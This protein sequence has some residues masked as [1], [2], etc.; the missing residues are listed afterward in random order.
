MA[1]LNTSTEGS[2]IT[3]AYRSIVESPGPANPSAAASPTYGQWAIFAVQAP[4]LSAFQNDGGKESVLRV[5]RTGEGE[6]EDMADEFS[7]GKI[8]YGFVKVKDPNTTLYKSVFIAWCG[9]GVPERTKGYF[10]SHTAA[11]QKVLHGYH[12]QI[13]ARNDNDL[14]PEN[15]IK[16]VQDSSGSKYS[17]GGA[18]PTAAD[19][20]KPPI[21]SKPVFTPSR[22][23]GGGSNFN[24]LGSRTRPTPAPMGNVDNDGW[25]EDAPSVTRSQIEKVTPA[26]QPTKVNMAELQSQKQES[27]Q[28]QQPEKDT[29]GSSDV[30]RGAY[31]PVGKVDIAAIRREAKEK[32]DAKDDRPTP[33]KGSY[34]PIGKVDIAAIRARAQ[35]PGGTSD[36]SAMSPSATGASQQSA[37]SSENESKSMADRSSAFTGS[38]R[39]S[40]MPKP[41]VANKFGAGAGTFTGTKAPVPGGYDSQTSVPSAPQV[42][43][44]SKTFA[45]QGGKTPAQLWAEKRGKQGAT[46]PPPA[47]DTSRAIPVQTSGGGGGWQ[48]GYTGKKW[49]SVQTTRTGA[50]AAS[51]GSVGA[52]RTGEQEPEPEQ[53]ATSPAGGGV[54]AMRDRFKNA[55]PMGTQPSGGPPPPMDLSSKP[56]AGER[57]AEETQRVPPPPPQVPRPDDEEEEEELDLRP[58]SPIRIAQPIARTAE[59]KEIPRTEEAGEPAPVMPSRSIAQ[60]APAEEDLEP[61]PAVTDHETARGASYAAAAGKRAIAQYDYKKAEENELELREGEEISNIDMV[62]EDW[63]MGENSGGEVGLFPA[64]YVELLPDDEAGPAPTATS[65]AAEAPR[66]AGG[67]GAGVS[68]GKTA[69]AEYD[70][71]AAEDNEL[72]FPEGAVIS[73]VVRVFS[74]DEVGLGVHSADEYHRNSLTRTGG[75]VNTMDRRDC[76]PRIMWCW[77]DEVVTREWVEVLWTRGQELKSQAICEERIECRVN[78]HV[79]LGKNV[80]QVTICRSLIARRSEPC[81]TIKTIGLKGTPPRGTTTLK[82]NQTNIIQPSCSSHHPNPPAPPNPKP[83]PVPSP[84]APNSPPQNS[85]P[86]SPSSS[87]PHTRTRPH[88]TAPPTSLHTPHSPCPGLP[89]LQPPLPRDST[90]LRLV[91]APRQGRLDSAS[92]RAHADTRL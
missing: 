30:V 8:Q 90:V 21:A 69:T 46:G 62:D 65:T 37:G 36:A 7:E 83:P 49:D 82:H 61:E 16:K 64:N 25:G 85:P 39:M 35:G 89:P 86:S 41:K 58:S 13:N 28:L 20:L 56:N 47:A 17:G 67:A 51:A 2:A 10:S 80:K 92:D 71:E 26:Y 75:W 15:I 34:E 42:G 52:Q 24:P 5:F 33:V 23:G 18:A 88:Q 72:T 3:K 55:P 14:I 40:S 77:M 4:L 91:K 70:Y 63:W 19:G 12:V 53:E 45:D 9:E 54:S 87:H 11:V 78:E 6:L 57:P 44:A 31:Q 38:G 59:P 32:G 81:Q 79:L 84:S 50:S 48:S 22:V 27:S 76:F 60:V 68:K 73:N 66:P 1:T 29:N 74:C 43:A